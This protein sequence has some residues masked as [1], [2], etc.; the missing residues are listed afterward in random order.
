MHSDVDVDSLNHYN[1]A[2]SGPNMLSQKGKYAHIHVLPRVNGKNM[3]TG[4]WGCCFF[5]GT[6]PKLPLTRAS[7]PE[8]FQKA[9]DQVLLGLPFKH[10]YLDDILVSWP[11]E[12]NLITLDAVLGSLEEYGLHVNQMNVYFSRSQW[13]TWP[14]SLMQQ[15]STNG[16]NKPLWM[17]LRPS[18]SAVW[19]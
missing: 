11:G 5:K 13:C 3:V 14:T 18:T 8:L 12:D 4:H 2:A 19:H 6:V 9:M 10:C 1:T 15:V 16:R 7:A 17:V